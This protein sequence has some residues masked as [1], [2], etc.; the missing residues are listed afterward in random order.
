MG[1]RRQ[2]VRD[3]LR[4]LGYERVAFLG[5]VEDGR[6]LVLEAERAGVTAKGRAVVAADGT[7]TFQALDTLRAFP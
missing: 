7:V 5:A 2:Q 3:H 4:A 1:D 6:V